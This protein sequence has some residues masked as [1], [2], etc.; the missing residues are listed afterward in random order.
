MAIMMTV[1]SVED[2]T[3]KGKNAYY[4]TMGA[5]VCALKVKDSWLSIG[6]RE[7]PVPWW[8]IFVNIYLEQRSDR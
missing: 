3:I 5:Q 6:S 1:R 4:S 7:F 2:L 8:T